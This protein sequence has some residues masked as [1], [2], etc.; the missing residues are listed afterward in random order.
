MEVAEMAVD[1]GWIESP[2]LAPEIRADSRIAAENT[3]NSW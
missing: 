1:L 3:W 2:A